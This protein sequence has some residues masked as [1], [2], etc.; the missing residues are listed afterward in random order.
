MQMGH[1]GE[2]VHRL[3]CWPIL[4][5]LRYVVVCGALDAQDAGLS[6]QRDCIR[7]TLVT[8]AI[9]CQNAVSNVCLVFL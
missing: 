5:R 4:E 7:N 3:R 8:V 2:L 1:R 9:L 6:Y